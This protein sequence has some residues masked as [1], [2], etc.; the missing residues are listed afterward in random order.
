MGEDHLLAIVLDN[1]V[2]NSKNTSPST[3]LHAQSEFNA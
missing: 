1:P 2:L 3:N